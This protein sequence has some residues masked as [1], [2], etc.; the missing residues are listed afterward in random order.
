MKLFATIV[1]SDKKAPSY[2]F[3]RVLNT[4][5]VV[6]LFS[7]NIGLL[8]RSEELVKRCSMEKNL[9]RLTKFHGNQPFFARVAGFWTTIL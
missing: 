8:G 5:L 7:D 2:M 9:K 3:D 4:L 1:R 6:S